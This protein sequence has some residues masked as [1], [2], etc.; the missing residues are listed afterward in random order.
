MTVTDIVTP[1]F[2]ALILWAAV[3]IVWR[4]D[5]RLLRRVTTSIVV[6]CRVLRECVG[7]RCWPNSASHIV[8]PAAKQCRPEPAPA[9]RSLLLLLC[10]HAVPVSVPEP[11]QWLLLLPSL[12]LV[13][14]HGH[15]GQDGENEEAPLNR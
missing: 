2:Q 8:F 5:S 12:A 1:I 6:G 7:I 14:D 11:A 10:R 9:W 4:T 13:A 15:F 3:P